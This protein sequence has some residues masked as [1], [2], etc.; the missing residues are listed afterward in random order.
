MKQDL[1]ESC[2]DSF[3]HH[4]EWKMT[5]AVKYNLQQAFRRLASYG[6]P[7]PMATRFDEYGRIISDIRHIVPK[8]KATVVIVDPDVYG[9]FYM[10]L[11]G[12]KTFFDEYEDLPF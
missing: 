3:I 1:A 8:T 7:M 11:E 12:K 6:K 10:S 2:K 9:R 4:I 5:P